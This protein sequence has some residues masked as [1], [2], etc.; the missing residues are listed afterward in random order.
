[1]KTNIGFLLIPLL[2][3]GASVQARFLEGS[4]QK[5]EKS[6]ISRDDEIHRAVDPMGAAIEDLAEEARR[7]LHR[8]TCEDLHSAV[9]GTIGHQDYMRRFEERKDAIKDK[10]ARRTARTYRINPENFWGRLAEIKAENSALEERIYDHYIRNIGRE[11]HRLL[12][13][14]DLTSQFMRMNDYYK[15]RRA[16]GAAIDAQDLPDETKGTMKGKVGDLEFIWPDQFFLEGNEISKEERDEFKMFCGFDGM[17]YRDAY[18]NVR[19]NKTYMVLCPGT[20]LAAVTPGLEGVPMSLSARFEYLA[21]VIGHEI[22]HIIDTREHAGAFDRMSG[23]VANEF[24]PS[25]SN[26]MREISADYWS[27][28]A[29]FQHLN[30]NGDQEEIRNFLTRSF[31]IIC[32]GDDD[33]KHPAVIIRLNTFIG[34]NPNLRRIAGCEPPIAAEPACTIAGETPAPPA[35]AST[36]SP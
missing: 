29:L 1:M 34:R 9:C 27:A 17:N 3:S 14:E 19:N 36:T 18:F 10:A 26:Y 28:E 8:L 11:L 16:M 4:Q 25:P 22:G 7:E 32:L 30:N 6:K 33:G 20:L 5:G 21:F 24:V 13:D 23:C 15:M 2:I 12:H 35:E 31:N